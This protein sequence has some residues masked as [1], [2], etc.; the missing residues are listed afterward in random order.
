MF[1]KEKETREVRTDH[2]TL[3][4]TPGLLNINTFL[5]WWTYSAIIFSFICNILSSLS[6]ASHGLFSPLNVFNISINFSEC[7]TSRCFLS[8]FPPICHLLY[9]PPSVGRLF[10][11]A[12]FATERATLFTEFLIF[13]SLSKWQSCSVRVHFAETKA[14]VCLPVRALLSRFTCQSLHIRA[15]KW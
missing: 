9:R 3:P 8:F 6:Y 13:S 15:A 12:L 1:K 4:N 2:K 11:P 7:L 5:R 10:P 14:F